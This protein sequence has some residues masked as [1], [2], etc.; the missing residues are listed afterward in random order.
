VDVSEDAK[1]LSASSI[2]TLSQN[3]EVVQADMS[4]K[5][6]LEDLCALFLKEGRSHRICSKL[7]FALSCLVRNHPQSE[8]KFMEH[9]SPLVVPRC[10][11]WAPACP[12]IAARA[13][14][15]C[16]ALMEADR[17]DEPRFLGLCSL[18]LPHSLCLDRDGDADLLE[19]KLLFLAASLRCEATHRLLGDPHGPYRAPLLAALSAL[20]SEQE[21]EL[22]ALVQDIQTQIVHPQFSLPRY[23]YTIHPPSDTPTTPS[24]PLLT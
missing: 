11:E 9:L 2:G 22:S 8:A 15:L 4:S 16:T 18:L 1:C 24:H 13:F 23:K 12:P 20:A 6:A 14:F 21:L 17:T 7:L 3:N 19:K 5:G 10:L